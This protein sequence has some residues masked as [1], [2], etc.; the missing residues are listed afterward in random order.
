MTSSNRKTS[1]TKGS[2]AYPLGELRTYRISMRV[3]AV[4]LA[5]LERRRSLTGA[6]DM[7]TY[8]RTALLAQRPPRAVAPELNRTAW[9][10]LA[11]HLVRMQE[12]AGR[13]EGLVA[14]PRGGLTG[15]VGRSRLED[16]V[17]TCLEELRAEDQQIQALRRALLGSEQGQR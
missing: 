12:L 9:L 5:E 15:L 8:A 4:E 13:L 10:T 7:G 14:R 6:R 17:N 3:N 11:E 16:A 1:P 2:Q